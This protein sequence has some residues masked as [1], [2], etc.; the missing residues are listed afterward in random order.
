MENF[1]ITVI[2]A[3]VDMRCKMNIL[4]ITD[5]SRHGNDCYIEELIVLVEAL[6]MYSVIVITKV[7]GSW[8]DE[9]ISASAPT[10]SYPKAMR[11][12][13][14]KGGIIENDEA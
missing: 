14:E 9:Q 3:I 12:Y 8:G 6:G 4:H 7:F 13:K 11:W 10:F 1:G 2:V 5:L